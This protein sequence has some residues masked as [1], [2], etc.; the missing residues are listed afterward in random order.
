MAARFSKRDQVRVELVGFDEVIRSFQALAELNP[1]T[2]AP[3]KK[4]MRAGATL[5]AR[6]ARA[7][8][9]SKGRTGRFYPLPGTHREYRAS[10]PGEPPAAVEKNLAK[11]IRTSISRKGFSARILTGDPKAHI[12]EYGSENQEARPFLRTSLADKARDVL[13]LLEQGY[14]AALGT[15]FR[16]RRR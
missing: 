6:E 13:K 4:A 7:K 11:S 14:I 8:L 12:Q 1:R 5:V 16:R 15:I 9:T 3:L 2:R 10:A